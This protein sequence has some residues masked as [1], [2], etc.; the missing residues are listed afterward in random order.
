[1]RQN[2]TICHDHILNINEMSKFLFSYTNYDNTA[3]YN[4]TVGVLLVFVTIR[5][6]SLL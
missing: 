4:F 2:Q 6:H 5:I 1:M 3:D